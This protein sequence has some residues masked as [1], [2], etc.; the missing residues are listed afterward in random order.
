MSGIEGKVIV[1]T[2]QAAALVRRLRSCSL[3]AVRRSSSARRP[4]RLIIL[5]VV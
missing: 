1:I 2:A 4:D 5:T 3:S